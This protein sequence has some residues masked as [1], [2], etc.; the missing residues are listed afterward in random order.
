MVR[1]DDPLLPLE[2]RERI[3]GADRAELSVISL[4]EIGQNVWL[5]KWPEKVPFAAGLLDRADADGFDLLPFHGLL[6]CLQRCSTGTT[7]TLST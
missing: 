4:Y 5:G 3:G 7:G 2:A 6:P 1:T